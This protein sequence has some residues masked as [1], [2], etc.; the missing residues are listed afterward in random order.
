MKVIVV[1]VALWGGGIALEAVGD[2]IVNTSSPF[3]TGLTIIG[4]QLGAITN[5]TDYNIACGGN[6][7]VQQ[8]TEPSY[9][10]TCINNTDGSGILAIVGIFGMISIISEFI[11]IQRY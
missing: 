4:Y 6:V 11:A 7:A 1:L 10:A 9:L 5:G 2:A 8:L 3:Y